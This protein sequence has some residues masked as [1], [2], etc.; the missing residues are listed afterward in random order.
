MPRAPRTH[1]EKTNVTLVSV[2]SAFASIIWPRRWL[3]LV[4]LVLIAINRLSA[5]V[6]PGATKYVLDDVVQQGDID[7]LWL[8]VTVV[9]VAIAVQAL[10]SFALTMLLSVEA[11][12][13][14]A[15]L[16][17]RVEA[18][19]IHLPIGYFDRNRSGVLVSRVMTDVEGVRN[20]IGT[21]LVQFVGGILTSVVAFT[22][23]VRIDA[24]M[25]ALALGPALLFGLIALAAFKMVRPIFRER[26]RIYAEV[27]GRLTETIGGIRV[28]KGF[29]AE[30]REH[31]V[32]VDGVER[33]FANVR[34]TLL[35]TSGVTAMAT[36]LLGIVSVTILAYG[37]QRILDDEMTV[38]EFVSFTLYL[39]FLVAPIVQMASIGTQITEAFAG[40]D[41]M[42]ELLSEPRESDDPR[43]THRLDDVRGHIELR[44]VR[45]AY[46]AGQHVLHGVS[47]VG[48]PG[49]VTALVGSSGSGKTT[50]AGLAAS[51]LTP[52]SGAVLVD[53]VDLSTVD[54]GTYRRH[55]GVVLQDDFLFEG[56]L[57]E[58]I[59]FG[60]PDASAEALEQAVDSAHVREFADRFTDG[61]ETVIGE[62]GV[63][64]SGGQRQRVAIARALLADPR[65]LILDEATS[66]LDTQSEA[67]VQESLARLMAGRTTFVIAHRLS[68]I[69]AADQIV[70]LEDG[71]I[72]E[73]GRHEELVASGGRY[74]EL[75]TYQARI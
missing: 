7:L 10:T 53:G 71:R 75:Y 40:L 18:H 23:M 67:F 20:L 39:A 27:T 52:T 22:L 9:G 60:S 44:D 65:V 45:F 41:R 47:L 54:V 8:I 49:T 72:V 73:R 74:H 28:V 68:T 19:V 3:L 11:Q 26:R 15:E 42:E 62:R 33:L 50:L 35:A 69:R 37:G 21:G 59:R 17:A 1:G 4:G 56:T 66:S 43:R 58:N 29:H 6:L 25:T 31:D 64:L 2:R 38:G 32:F 5:L 30:Q 48:E 12:R 24:T 46:D 13:L 36:L 34:K 63:R 16:R 14:I 51:F 70:V 57:R 55:L 61:L